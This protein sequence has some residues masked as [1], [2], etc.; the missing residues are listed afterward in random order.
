MSAQGH[1]KDQL[2]QSQEDI[3]KNPKRARKA[4]EKP[5]V[6]MNFQKMEKSRSKHKDRVRKQAR[7]NQQNMDETSS[8]GDTKNGVDESN[9]KNKIKLLMIF[10]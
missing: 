8:S 4:P 1:D 7:R 3:S 2:N 10:S 6:L 5:E 9:N